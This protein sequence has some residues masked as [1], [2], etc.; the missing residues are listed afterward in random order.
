[1]AIQARRERQGIMKAARAKR[2][3]K[4]FDDI[5]D[6]LVERISSMLALDGEYSRS[7]VEGCVRAE[8]A[9]ML[10]EGSIVD[11]LQSYDIL[12]S[13][14]EESF[15]GRGLDRDLV[16][17]KDLHMVKK[18]DEWYLVQ[19]YGLEEE[20]RTREKRREEERKMRIA[21]KEEH[22]EL[23]Q[24]LDMKK[25][26]IFFSISNYILIVVDLSRH[27]NFR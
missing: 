9:S 21:S 25:K 5:L 6:E 10:K 24:Q 8:V 7:E 4:T 1:M 2:R 12:R 13:R 27:V 16:K 17:K 11:G 22:S 15:Q 20:K 19:Q 14:I 18:R 23:M 3:M 26:V